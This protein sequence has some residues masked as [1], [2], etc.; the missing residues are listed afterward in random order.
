ML[1]NERDYRIYRDGEIETDDQLDCLMEHRDS[2]NSLGLL[3]DPSLVKITS[4]LASNSKLRRSTF[5]L[6]SFNSLATASSDSSSYCVSTPT[7]NASTPTRKS[8]SLRYRGSFQSSGNPSSLEAA[9]KQSLAQRAKLSDSNLR[10]VREEA[11]GAIPS[12]NERTTKIRSHET[13]SG[14]SFAKD[15]LLEWLNSMIHFFMEVIVLGFLVVP[16]LEL[17]IRIERYF[18]SRLEDIQQ[19]SGYIFDSMFTPSSS[20]QDEAIDVDS[21]RFL[22]A[23]NTPMLQHYQR[24]LLDNNERDLGHSSEAVSCY[25]TSSSSDHDAS[26]E[27][28]EDGW[29]HFADFQD[30]LADET[31]FVPCSFGPLDIALETLDEGREEDD[32]AG[33]DWAF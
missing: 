5:E 24:Q 14:T 16:F 13:L 18:R 4:R 32:D 23:E 29:G 31:S 30:E 17:I 11:G 27:H 25:S 20:F 12:G 1:L 33:E 28:G 19:S 2:A 7:R 15:G 21:A 6:S 8:S 22:S 26:D 9:P 10:E 3:D